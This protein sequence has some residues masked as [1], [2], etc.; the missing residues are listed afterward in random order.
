MVSIF[1]NNI[2]I[3]QNGLVQMNLKWMLLLGKSANADN[4][5][6]F[7]IIFIEAGWC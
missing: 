3:D 1:S 5:L 2:Y 6:A 4:F 7:T